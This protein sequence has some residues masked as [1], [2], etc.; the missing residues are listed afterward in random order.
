MYMYT[1]YE[2]DDWIFFLPL[3]L[4]KAWLIQNQMVDP[5]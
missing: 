3:D 4:A 5:C 1:N 2:S